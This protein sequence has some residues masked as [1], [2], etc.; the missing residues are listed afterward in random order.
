MVKIQILNRKTASMKLRRYACIAAA[1]LALWGINQGGMALY[2]ERVRQKNYKAVAIALDNW[3]LETASGL[4]EKFEKSGA[5]K[6][7]DLETLTLELTKREKI[8]EIK[9]LIQIN[10]Y[11]SANIKLQEL[12]ALPSQYHWDDSLKAKVA[13]IQTTIEDNLESRLYEN[14][15]SSLRREVDIEASCE[16]YLRVHPN[17]EHREEVFNSWLNYHYSEL[18]RR[19]E[20]KNGSYSAIGSIL[21]HIEMLDSIIQ[22]YKDKK[23]ISEK[24]VSLER[25]RELGQEYLSHYIYNE[26]VFYVGSLVRVKQN[27]KGSGLNEMVNEENTLNPSYLIERMSQIPVG[28][29]GRILDENSKVGYYVVEFPSLSINPGVRWKALSE[30]DK[31]SI[32][33]FKKDELVTISDATEEDANNFWR[34]YQNLKTALSR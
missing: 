27:A 15:Q 4:L 7:G 31:K 20:K 14:V 22:G 11:D 9:H 30:Y 2:R 18:V 32:G 3:E 19:L 29:S 8:E 34:A 16:K 28:S 5:I 25:I 6:P 24:T 26:G 10:Q 17:G 13:T 1:L 12:T 33:A 23:P 21:P